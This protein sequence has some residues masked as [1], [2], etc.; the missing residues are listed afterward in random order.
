LS[1]L[2]VV[3]H[4]DMDTIKIFLKNSLNLLKNNGCLIIETV[5]PHS[6]FAFGGFYMDETHI[7]PIPPEQLTFLMQWCGF[8]DIEVIYSSPLPEEF[9]STEIKRNYYDYALIGYKR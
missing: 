7:R 9:I 8:K 2:Q 3:E 5:N 6:P 4:L 1:A